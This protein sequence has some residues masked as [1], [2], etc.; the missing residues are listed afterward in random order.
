MLAI[1][2]GFTSLPL[3][4]LG[5]AASDNKRTLVCIFQRGAMDGIAAV[6]P[7]RDPNLRQLRPALTLSAGKGTDELLDLDGRFGLH[8]SFRALGRLY[9]E[10]RL[11]IVHGVG[12]PT[13]TR[14]HF[15]AQDYVETGTPGRKSTPDGWLNRAAAQ[16]EG[17]G[18]P[19]RTVSLTPALP[20]AM[21]GEQYAIAVEQLTDLGVRGAGHGAGGSGAGGFEALYRQTSEQLLRQAGSTGLDAANMLSAAELEAYRPAAG[22]RYPNSS[23]GRGLRQIAQLIKADVGL[24]IAFAE[25]PGWDTHTRQGGRFGRF[26]QQ[27]TDLSNGI[28]NFWRDLGERQ[29]RVTLMTVT[30]FGR[31][32]HQNGS[33]GTDHGRGSCAFVV[34]NGFADSRVLGEVPT[35]LP[36]NLED[37]RDLPVTTDFRAYFA[38]V[39]G[40]RLGVADTG[41]LFP[42]WSGQPLGALF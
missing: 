34:D 42:G 33:G 36:A 32:I 24:E 7:L 17:E 37:G 19:L 8:P 23:L 6:Q 11:R 13:A 14:S 15:D 16:L 1:G 28:A 12:L 21:Y 18:T 20:R 4:A 41:S 22:V 9:G 26:N 2:G 25:S 5:Q 27:A 3:R 29:D 31:T 38:A 35:L 39:A 10:G 30:E 40:H